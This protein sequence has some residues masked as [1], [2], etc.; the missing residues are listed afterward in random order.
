[1][2]VYK[3][4]FFLSNSPFLWEEATE[5]PQVMALHQASQ[6]VAVFDIQELI[7]P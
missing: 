2:Y 1:M 5:D 6:L 7:N 4:T 3:N